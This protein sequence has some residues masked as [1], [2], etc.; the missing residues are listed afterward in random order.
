LDLLK[1]KE[2]EGKFKEEL[3]FI[4]FESYSQPLFKMD[5]P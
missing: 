4:K 5:I 2:E 1:E 3:I